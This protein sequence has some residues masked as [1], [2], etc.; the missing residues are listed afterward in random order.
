MATLEQTAKYIR[1]KN[2][3]PFALTFDIFCRDAESY[4]KIK[5]SKNI[6]PVVFANTYHVKEKDVK[7]YYCQDI[8][9]IKVSIPRPIIQGDKY[10]RDIHGCQ[11]C[12]L[13]Y[14]MEV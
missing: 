1:S 12:L 4:K 6:T 8:F 9:A 5:N 13:L 14:D 2:A 10:E 3:G 7:Y 11:Q